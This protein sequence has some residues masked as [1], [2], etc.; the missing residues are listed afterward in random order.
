MSLSTGTAKPLILLIEGESLFSD[1]ASIITFEAFKDLATDLSHFEATTFTI[2]LILKVF[3]SPLLGFIMSKI[4]MFWLSYIFNDGLI[5][6]TISLAMTYITFYFAEWLGMS[7]VIAVLIMG[8]LLDT[9][10]FSPEIEV[11]LLR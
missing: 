9:V 10:N 7:G 8:L 2:K 1:G 5:E 3:G 6:I 11:F 4:I